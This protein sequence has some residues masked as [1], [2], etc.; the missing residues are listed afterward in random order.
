V[1]YYIVPE[2]FFSGHLKNSEG[3]GAPRY[4]FS[5]RCLTIVMRCAIDA[6]DENNGIGAVLK[7]KSIS[8]LAILHY[9]V[10]HFLF[11]IFYFFFVISVVP[12]TTGSPQTTLWD[13]ISPLTP[14]DIVHGCQSTESQRTCIFFGSRRML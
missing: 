12:L 2:L 1:F 8:V 4:D 3:L 5:A 9:L 11:F 13:A 6:K 10:M 7:K 14:Y